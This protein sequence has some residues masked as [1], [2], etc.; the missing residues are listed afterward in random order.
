MKPIERPSSRVIRVNVLGSTPPA[1]VLI[2][3]QT[4]ECRY[5]PTYRAANCSQYKFVPQG[6]EGALKEAVA[7]IGPISVAVNS[8]LG[9]FIFYESGEST[10][11]RWGG[12][13][14][15]ADGV[16]ILTPPLTQGCTTTPTA[17]RR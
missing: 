7:T 1:L 10:S 17:T 13:R 16:F 8:K 3:F 14:G 15:K 9:T 2:R 4:G 6:D 11:Q 12:G 5:N